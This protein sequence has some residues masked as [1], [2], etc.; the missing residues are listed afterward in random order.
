MLKAPDVCCIGGFFVFA[1][2]LGV[3]YFMSLSIKNLN[4]L[5]ERH[6]KANL[7]FSYG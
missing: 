1:S 3:L 4:N 7:F 5:S 2:P 6:I